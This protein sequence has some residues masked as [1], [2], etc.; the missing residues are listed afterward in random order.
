MELYYFSTECFSPELPV[1]F[2]FV[3]TLKALQNRE[4]VLIECER[5]VS[6]FKTKLLVII[7]RNDNESLFNVEKYDQIFV[8]VLDGKA[9]VN[10]ESIDLS[11]LKNKI[12]DIG[13]ITS[14]H[15]KATMWQV[16][17]GGSEK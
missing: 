11:K 12:L 16:K 17:D 1:H 5:K 4:V 9:F 8:Y 2:H 7:P 13:G 14:S 15:E 3:K 10:R 6:N